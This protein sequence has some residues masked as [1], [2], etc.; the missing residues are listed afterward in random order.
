MKLIS[1][2]DSSCV[3][4]E[5]IGTVGFFDGVHRGHRYLINQLKTYAQKAGLKTAV[6]TFPVH[7]RKILQQD[8][9]PKLL[10]T[11]EER[12]A[13]LSSL[14]I[15]F[16][17][18]I[19]FSPALSEITAKDFIRQILHKQLRIKELLVGYDHKFGKGRIGEYEQFVEYG[20]ACGMLTHKAEKWQNEDKPI[21]STTIR[22]LLAE[23][24][25]KDAA[26]ALSYCYSLEGQV[27]Q[28]D[29]LGR[30][31]DFPT[32]NLSLCDPDKIIPGHGAYTVVGILGEKRYAG[33]AYIGWRP[34]VAIRMENRVEV[35]LLNFNE[36]IYGKKIR[37]EFIEF[38]RPEIHFNCIDDLRAQ[39][40]KDRADVQK[41]SI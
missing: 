27:V 9:Q 7:P 11:L 38:L 22:H 19:N 31:L 3:H 40:L 8:Y 26:N 35:H 21:S 20:A 24:K 4:S 10:N 25:V 32:A 33:M 2:H 28:G 13:Q 15:D 36:D 18:L 30:I 34:T 14:E 6:V 37:I 39:L 23:G 29:R 16:C 12:I 17:Y 5:T 41:I 1:I